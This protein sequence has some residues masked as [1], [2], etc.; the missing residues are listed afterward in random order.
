M[1]H[2]TF[3]PVRSQEA[4]ER[5]KNELNVYMKGLIKRRDTRN[6]KE[7]IKFLDLDKFA[8]ELLYKK[9]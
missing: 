3:L 7:L 9:P 1:P 5:R 6:S 2:K 4:L 8:P